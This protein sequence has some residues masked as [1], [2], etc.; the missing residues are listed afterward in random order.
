[1]SAK[2]LEGLYKTTL[3]FFFC[4]SN[5]PGDRQEQHARKNGLLG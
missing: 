5:H 1:M 2:T 4:F 3:L